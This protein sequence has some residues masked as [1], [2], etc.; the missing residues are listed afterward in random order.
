MQCATRGGQRAGCGNA[1]Q[2]PGPEGIPMLHPDI[3][4]YESP[5]AGY[6]LVAS[7]RIPAGAV[8]CAPAA[9][10]NVRVLTHR[11]LRQLPKELHHLAYR[12]KDHYV[13]TEDNSQFMN[14]SCDPSTWWLDD[15]TLVARRDIH[16]GEEVAYD[17]ATSEVHPWWRPKW[18]CRCGASSCRKIISGRDCL[19]PDFQDHYAG[20]LPSWTLDFIAKNRGV[21]GFAYA[22]LAR[23][24]E[25]VR[26]VKAI[27]GRLH[28]S[29]RR[30]KDLAVEG[31]HQGR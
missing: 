27:L 21:R 9:G 25:S 4:R 22:C 24:A 31:A 19:D 26:G 20:H 5:V 28:L 23:L 10:E 1:A 16:A 14:H 2:A 13:L 7:K 11:Q 18:T 29:I 17:Y 8:I 3:V 30:S 6:G 15:D 12:H